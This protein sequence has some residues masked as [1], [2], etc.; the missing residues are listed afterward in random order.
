MGFAFEYRGDCGEMKQEKNR[1]PKHCPLAKY[2]LPF[3]W[4]NYDVDKDYCAYPGILATSKLNDSERIK[5]FKI[6][7]PEVMPNCGF[8]YTSCWIFSEWY[9]HQVAKAPKLVSA[10][11]PTRRAIPPAMRHEVF[12]RGGYKCVECGST[13]K[14]SVLHVDH[15]LPVS[16]RGGDEL[17]N[18]QILCERCNKSKSVRVWK[19]DKKD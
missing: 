16:R 8:D 9:W 3:S 19:G 14:D 10:P 7:C 15:I 17:E 4:V 13:N 18:L 1:I 2:G 11:T 6:V 5:R 12:K